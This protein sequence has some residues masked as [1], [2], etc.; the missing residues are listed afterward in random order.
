M[1]PETFEREKILN[2]KAYAHL[3]EQ[4]RREHAG[5]YVALGLERVLTVA[6]T[7]DEV[8]AVVQ[9]L[10]PGLE[11]YLIFPADAEPCFEPYYSY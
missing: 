6:D 3:R 2:E 8:K 5:R 4:I 7:Y 1:D 11:F 9:Q 10:Y